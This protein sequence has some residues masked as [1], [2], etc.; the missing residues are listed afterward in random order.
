MQAYEL[1]NTT[2]A[3]LA[4]VG[5]IVLCFKNPKK[6]NAQKLDEDD[7]LINAVIIGPYLSKV[8]YFVVGMIFV[9]VDNE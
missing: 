6:V 4:T 7:Y 5:L 9:G 1:V 8:Y 3:F 2:I